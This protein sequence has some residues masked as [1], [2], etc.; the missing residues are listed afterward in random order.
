MGCL[1]AVGHLIIT[2]LSSLPRHLGRKLKVERAEV[3]PRMR[4]RLRRPCG[5]HQAV[6]AGLNA[7]AILVLTCAF[8]LDSRLEHRVGAS[9]S[10]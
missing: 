9:V 7:D 8:T 4:W 2:V 10:V 1:G 6:T 5:W 3:V